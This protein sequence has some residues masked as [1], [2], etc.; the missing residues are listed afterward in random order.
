VEYHWKRHK[1]SGS[2]PGVNFFGLKVPIPEFS[3]DKFKTE[4]AYQAVMVAGRVF[5]DDGFSNY[6]S[7][8]WPSQYH[9]ILKQI[10]LVP[11]DPARVIPLLEKRDGYPNNEAS[12]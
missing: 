2:P 6:R 10:F 9:T 11:C 4:G 12:D 8:T 3:Q 7:Q 5:Y 1:L